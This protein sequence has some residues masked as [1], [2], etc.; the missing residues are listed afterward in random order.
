MSRRAIV[1]PALAEAARISGFSPAV[2]AGDFIFLTGATG[3][4]A[5]GTMPPDAATQTRNALSKV[6]DILSHVGADQT[7]V[8]EMTTYHSN[9]EDDFTA[10]EEVIHDIF[11]GPLPAWT[12][13]EVARL[14]RPGAR[15]ELRIVVYHPGS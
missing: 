2:R 8:V 11:T 15:I 12:A 13:V 6:M 7:D 10:V 14:R 1:S 3:G 5:N 9:I 4:A